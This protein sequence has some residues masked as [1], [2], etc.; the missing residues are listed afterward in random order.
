MELVVHGSKA[1][2]MEIELIYIENGLVSGFMHRV[3]F[4]VIIWFVNVELVGANS[5]DWA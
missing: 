4:V 3:E 5:N 2:A 1:G